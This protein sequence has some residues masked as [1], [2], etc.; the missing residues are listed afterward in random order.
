VLFLI[1]L[2]SRRVEFAGLARQADGLWMSQVARNLRDAAEGF[3]VGKRYMIHDRDPLFTAE[4]LETLGT[5]GVQSVKLPPRSPNLNAHAERFVRTI[6]QGCLERR[7][8][9][10]E[11]SFR[12]A[13]HEFVEHYH[14]QRNHQG[15]G[16]R[17]IIKDERGTCSCGPI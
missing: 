14:R 16:N 11:G 2:S 8:R 1:D 10:G 7:V 15:L 5:R 17:P 13:I 9:F 4:S 6:K 12:K 3:L